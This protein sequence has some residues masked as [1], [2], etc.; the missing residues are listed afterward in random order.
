MKMNF[1]MYTMERRLEMTLSVQT[2]LNT[3]IGS[4]R[5]VTF[6]EHTVNTYIFPLLLLSLADGLS[7]GIV[8]R[9]HRFPELFPYNIKVYLCFC[10]SVPWPLV[11]GR[12]FLVDIE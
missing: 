3:S 8:A 9:E 7:K 5:L 12:A 11:R 1:D 10:L 4:T 6:T 2:N